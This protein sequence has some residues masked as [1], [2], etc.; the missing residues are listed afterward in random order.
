MR[1]RPSAVL[2]VT[3]AVGALSA[4]SVALPA[5]GA[6]ARVLRVG[7]WHGVAGTYSSIQAAIDAAHAGDWVLVGPGD[8]KERG[9][10]TTHKPA[11]GEAGWAVTIETPGLHLRG[12]NRNSVVVDGTK[13]GTPKCS[14]ARADQ[15]FGHSRSGIV[16]SKVDGT[17]VENLTVC[18]F[19]GEGNQIW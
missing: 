9:D 11:K 16:V 15:E 13:P 17:Y 3:A 10:F 14:S 8:W 7:T 12:M 5:S 6:T 19:L 1:L 2:M 18:N 4:A